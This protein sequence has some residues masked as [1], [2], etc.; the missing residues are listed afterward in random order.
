MSNTK[1]LATC[2]FLRIKKDLILTFALNQ[3]IKA[4]NYCK[5]EN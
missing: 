1:Y 5:K 4:I 2:K 3:R